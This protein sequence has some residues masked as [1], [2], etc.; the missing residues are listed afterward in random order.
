ME[1]AGEILESLNKLTEEKNFKVGD[2]IVFRANTTFKIG[3]IIEITK[4]NLGFTS[5]KCQHTGNMGTSFNFLEVRKG[6][7]TFFAPPEAVITLDELKQKAKEA[8]LRMQDVIQKFDN[9]LLLDA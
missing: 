4:D 8:L 1:Q 3:K 7:D 2:K 9:L 6:D 5:L